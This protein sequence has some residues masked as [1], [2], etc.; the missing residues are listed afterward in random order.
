M[1]HSIAMLAEMDILDILLAP[2]M[3]I[4]S[5]VVGAGIVLGASAI[6]LLAIAAYSPQEM[7]TCIKVIRFIVLFPFRL[8]GFPFKV[9][10][11][12]LTPTVQ[13]VPSQKRT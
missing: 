8:V 11:K 9:L 13:V 12:V 4:L 5:I 1:I 10:F 7:I 2:A 3:T 6:P